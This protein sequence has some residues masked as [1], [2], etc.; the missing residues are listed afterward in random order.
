ME[1]LAEIE[2]LETLRLASRDVER[3]SLDWPELRRVILADGGIG[4]SRDWERDAVPGDLFRLAGKAPDLMAVETRNAPWDVDGG[5]VAMMTYLQRSYAQWQAHT[6]S[7][8]HRV[9]KTTPAPV[10]LRPGQRSFAELVR[11][12]RAKHGPAVDLAGLR[13]EY[14][15]AYESG[16]RVSVTRDG[17]EYRGTIG[18]TR[19]P[20]PRF[21]LLLSLDL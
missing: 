14:V 18:A 9:V 21:V 11:E 12:L 4:P 2:E 5:D 7:A 8:P 15:S 3:D 6:S 10:K 17:R 20:R 19:G 16:E 1:L 13:P